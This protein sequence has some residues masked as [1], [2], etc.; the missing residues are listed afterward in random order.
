MASLEENYNFWNHNYDWTR[1]GGE[2]W[3]ARWGGSDL[4][5]SASLW[6]RLADHLPAETVVE[7]APGYGRW[8]HYLLQ[9][10]RDLTLVDLSERC[11]HACKLR[12]KDDSRLT[13]RVGDGRSLPGVE[14]GSVDLVFSF[15]SLVHAELEV[16]DSYLKEI[17]RVLKPGGV[18]FLHHSNAGGFH[19]YF[20][21]SAW[22]PKP[23]RKFLKR[24]GWLDYGEWRAQSVTAELI[25]RA[26]SNHGLHCR[27]QELIPWGGRRVIDCFS[28]LST[29]PGPLV[30]FS[31]RNFIHRAY[32]VQRL[33]YLYGEGVP[34]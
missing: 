9:H 11:I 3:S 5:W 7:I 13:F 6:P 31:N 21:T 16:M 1:F 10:C 22:V 4:Q 34:W 29:E 33:S 8:S 18:A 26:A 30:R 19:K 2:E 32:Q 12:F 14:D 25:A 20:A 23:M 28:T 17:R 24:R 15:E 27:V